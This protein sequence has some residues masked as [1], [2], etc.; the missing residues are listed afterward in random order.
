MQRFLVRRLL[1]SLLLIYVIVSATFFLV[2]L[3][4]GGPEGA[5]GGGPRDTPEQ[6]A[7]LRQRWGLDQPLPVQYAVF[8]TNA[9]QL[10]FGRSIFHR[11]PA[12]EV[13]ASRLGPTLQLGLA[14]YA[15]G[16][17]GVP[18]GSYAALHRGRLGDLAVRVG[19]SLGHALP[20]WWPGLMAIF[21]LNGL[22]GWF[23]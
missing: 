18:L 7:R 8:F 13:I 17:L 15:V 1:Q 21:L 6:R 11:V 2:H 5:F 12:T 22:V 16:L 20:S 4:P 23:P 9:V 14:S 3:A 19:T 10:D